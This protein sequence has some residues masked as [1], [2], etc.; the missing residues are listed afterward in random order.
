[1][2]TPAFGVAVIAPLVLVLAVG[3][4]APA[5]RHA[6]AD[7]GITPLAAVARTGD[8]AGV[9][10]IAAPKAPTL[11]ASPSPTCPLLHRRSS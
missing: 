8:D 10:V 2:R 6:V 11:F 1:M 9:V 4:S 3:A 5:P 7:D